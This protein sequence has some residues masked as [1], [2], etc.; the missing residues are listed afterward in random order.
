MANQVIIRL[1]AMGD[2]LL[3]VPVARELGAHHKVFWIINKKWQELSQFLP[4]NVLFF[5]GPHSLLETVKKIRE[6]DPETVF[7][8]QGKISSVFMKYLS[9]KKFTSYQKRTLAEQWQ[10]SSGKYPIK[11]SNSSP[12]WQ[13]YATSAKIELKNPNPLL[14]LSA[15]YLSSSKKLAKNIGL[16]PGNF[17]LIHPDASKPGKV[18]PENGLKEIIRNATCQIAL[19]GT[20]TQDFNLSEFSNLIDLRNKLLLGQLPGIMANSRGVISTD[21]GPMHLARATNVPL[22]CLFFQTDPSLGFAPVP[23]EKNFIVSKTLPCKPCS[24]HGQRSVC[25][26]GHFNCR[27]L[28][29]DSVAKEIWSFMDGFK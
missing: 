13:R 27:T 19:I 20:G 25:P 16:E 23:S 8:L 3:A 24:I 14:N 15:E 7:D 10:V 6:I 2:I 9:G 29:W 28:K 5:D 26:E 11:I 21:S 18:L 1:N 22:T 12:V 17:I 4:A